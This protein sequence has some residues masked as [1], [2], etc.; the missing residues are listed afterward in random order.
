MQTATLGGGCFWCVEACLRELDGVIDV[1]PGLASHEPSGAD[2]LDDPAEVVQV[3]FDPARLS[4][5]DLLAVFFRVH[6]PTTR[7][8][9][10]D[11]VGRE[12]RSVIFYHDDEQRAVA[13]HAIVGLDGAFADP[14]V[15]ELSPLRA[16]RAAADK[17]HDYFRRN[18]EEQYCRV[19][20]APKIE[21]LRKLMSTVTASR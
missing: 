1:V 8:R 17:H 3:R 11:D 20:I 18:P 7:D 5:L 10:G 15:T 21:K 2:E 6:D 19:I 12:Y 14:V 13:A 16:F 9:Q 4:F